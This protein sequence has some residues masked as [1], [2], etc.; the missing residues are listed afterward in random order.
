[1]ESGPV[2]HL[3]VKLLLHVTKKVRIMMRCRHMARQYNVFLMH[4]AC[5]VQRV[6]INA[7]RHACMSE[8]NAV[9]RCIVFVFNADIRLNLFNLFEFRFMRVDALAHT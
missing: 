4:A 2:W 1:M 5:K 3:N 8:C 7:G 6:A 9:I